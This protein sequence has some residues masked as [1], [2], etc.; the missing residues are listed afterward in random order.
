MK[1]SGVV[2]CVINIDY[3]LIHITAPSYDILFAKVSMGESIKNFAKY[4]VIKV[5]IYRLY[6]YLFCL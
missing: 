6:I 2:Y 1:M 5:K 3:F 4:K